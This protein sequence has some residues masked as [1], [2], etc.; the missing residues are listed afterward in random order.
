MDKLDIYGLDYK[1]GAG[2]DDEFVQKLQV[3]NAKFI[4]ACDYFVVHQDH[5]RL[6]GVWHTT[7]NVGVANR[8]IEKLRSEIKEG[9]VKSYD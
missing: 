9:R 1:A 6:T 7:H 5:E 8:R 3:V 2:E 4:C